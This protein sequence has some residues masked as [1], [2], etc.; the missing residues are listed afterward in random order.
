MRRGNTGGGI[1]QTHPSAPPSLPTLPE[2]SDGTLESTIDSPDNENEI[3][4][5]QKRG[6]FD[7]NDGW[8]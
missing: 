8:G 2:D 7:R 6:F 4:E 3:P 1:R 5:W